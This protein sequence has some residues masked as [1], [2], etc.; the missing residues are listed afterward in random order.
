MITIYFLFANA[1]WGSLKC[2]FHGSHIFGLINFTDF[3]SIFSPFP[4]FFKVLFNEFIKYKNLFNKYISI[5]KSEKKINKNW[6]KFYHF[7]SILGKFPHS[8]LFKIPWS[9]TG[10]CFPF[11]SPCGN[12][13]CY[14]HKIQLWN[15]LGYNNQGSHISGLTNFPDFSSIFTI[16]PVFIPMF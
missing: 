7:F 1:N 2:T 14:F 4:V 8:S 5:K 11:S 16:F 6:L 15:H 12:H 9:L 10:K 13:D 3:P